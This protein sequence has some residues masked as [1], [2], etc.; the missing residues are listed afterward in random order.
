M[1]GDAARPALR[2]EEL[3]PG[4]VIAAFEFQGSARIRYAEQLGEI[5]DGRA[6][7]RHLGLQVRPDTIGLTAVVRREEIGAFGRRALSEHVGEPL[8]TELA[9]DAGEG[10]RITSGVAEIM[11]T[12]EIRLTAGV[13]ASLAVALMAS[14]AVERVQSEVGGELG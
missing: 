3:A 4:G 11:V 13:G 8:R 9:A 12:L 2:A 10:R 1:A 14:D 7:M 6:V 5:R